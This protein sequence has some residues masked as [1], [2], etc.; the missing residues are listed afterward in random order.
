MPWSV[1]FAG[2]ASWLESATIRAL[3][4]SARIV[5]LGTCAAETAEALQRY[6]SAGVVLFHLGDEADIGLRHLE[7]IVRLPEAGRI[8][9]TS[10]E[11]ED[12]LFGRCVDCGAWGFVAV[13]S[14]IHDHLDTI[15]RVSAGRL[16]YPRSILDRIETSGG[17]MRMATP[18]G[19]FAQ[20]L[21][22]DE[23]E[24]FTLLAEGSTTAAA[25][26]TLGIDVKQ[27]RRRR[28]RIMRKLR[29]ANVASL[30]RLAIREG[31]I[32]P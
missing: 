20:H 14:S 15:R 5:C 3:R 11:R 30:V 19:A 18:D 24:L 6:T 29:L 1:I 13:E 12:A 9:A 23:L 16:C 4:S 8:I 2:K 32:L 21:T 26:M 22:S 10:D 17:Q 25:A 7:S 28:S 31:V 27:A